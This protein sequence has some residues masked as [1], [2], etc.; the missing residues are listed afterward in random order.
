VN[1]EHDHAGKITA[2]M[3]DRRVVPV[4]ARSPRPKNF[5]SLLEVA[6]H[7]QEM[8]QSN[9]KGINAVYEAALAA[10]DYA[11]Q[12]LMHWLSMNRSRKKPGA[13]KWLKRVQAA[14]CAGAFPTSTATSN[15]TSPETATG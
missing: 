8:E 1:E 14:N 3:I 7:A 11:A 9:T 15:D 6:Q 2:H 12:V 10:K 5:K 4:L 13:S